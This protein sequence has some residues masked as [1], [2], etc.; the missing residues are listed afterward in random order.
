MPV[1]LT[2]QVG[3]PGPRPA[4]GAGFWPGVP[5]TRAGHPPPPRYIYCTSD[6]GKT[7]IRYICDTAHST[8]ILHHQ[9]YITIDTQ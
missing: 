4:G 3:S 1:Y 6:T 8:T 7:E 9:E 2:G 5:L